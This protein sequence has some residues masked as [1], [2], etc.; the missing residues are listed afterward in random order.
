MAGTGGWCGII[1]LTAGLDGG[2]GIRGNVQ[3]DFVF[4]NT[5]S[6]VKIFKK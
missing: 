3:E 6:I 2:F 4:Y 1:Q 5:R